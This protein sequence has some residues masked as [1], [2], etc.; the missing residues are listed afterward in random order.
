MYQHF[1]TTIHNKFIQQN[2]TNFCS[3]LKQPHNATPFYPTMEQH[4]L[5]KHKQLFEYQ[6]LLLITDIWWSKF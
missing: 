1:L 4:S 6:H 2:C 5:K 3:N